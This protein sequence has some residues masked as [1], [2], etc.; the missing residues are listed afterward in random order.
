VKRR[1]KAG[2]GAAGANLEGTAGCGKDPSGS[3]GAFGTGVA[4]PRVSAFKPMVMLW[5][6]YEFFP[7]QGGGPANHFI[8]L[9][10]RIGVNI[11]P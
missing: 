5:V 2:C 6:L 10:T 9:G 3:R 11:D 8:G 7:P 4:T 1:A